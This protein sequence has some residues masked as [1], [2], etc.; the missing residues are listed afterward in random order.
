MLVLAALVVMSTPW[1]EHILER[2]V[3][4]G[5]EDVTGGRAEI[6]YFRFNPWL[7]HI[8][9]TDLVIHGSEPAG[10]LPILVARDLEAG[11]SP[12]RLLRRRLRLRHLDIVELQLRLRTNSQGITNLPLSAKRTSAQQGFRSLMDLSIGRLTISHSAVYWNDQQEP[13]EVQSRELAVLLH[14]TG[15]RYSGAL[16]SSATT[17]GIPGWN[18]PPITFNG[19]FELSAANFV[20]SSFAWQA[21]GTFGEA[22]FTMLPRSTVEGSGSFHASIEASLAG[23]IFAAP[24]LRG[25]ALQIE[26]QAVYQGGTISAQGRAQARQIEMSTPALHS[27]RLDATTSYDLEDHRLNLSNLLIS[28]WGGTVQGTFAGGFRRL[29]TEVSSEFQ[30]L[31]GAVGQCAGLHERAAPVGGPDSPGID[32]EWGP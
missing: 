18:S 3:I 4:A 1:F 8:R 32:G 28:I 16:S 10:A 13:V 12:G 31:R 15:G 9:L 5:L 11:I 22:A 25:G 21:A 14:L 19:R 23:R 20:F 2:Q 30:A 27:L 6:G 7:F 26:G 17:I 29:V 24:E